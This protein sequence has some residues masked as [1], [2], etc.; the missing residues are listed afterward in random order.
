MDVVI[1]SRFNGPPA[2]ANG[3]YAAGVLAGFVAGT[4]EV[5]LLRPPPLD[6]PM[7]VIVE[8]DR[9]ALRHGDVVVAT[10]R[11]VT[12]E[13]FPVPPVSIEAARAASERGT[14][15]D[16]AAAAPFASCFTCGPDRAA[17]D[18]L[19]VFAGVVDGSPDLL[20]APWSP[21]ADVADGDGVVP[22]PV[23]WAALDC[24]GGWAA[25]LDAG[26]P[27]LLG[28]MTARIDRPVIAGE[29]HV[30]T[31]RS[32]GRNNRKLYA[33]TSIYSPDGTC[34][35]TAAATWITVDLETP[36]GARHD[37]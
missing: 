36:N 23:V 1:E 37:R 13:V 14:G 34:V 31:A 33:V 28:R 4:A 29:P 27:A 17:G 8:D 30:I 20:A 10:A 22:D 12:F 9:V 35:A 21:S 24:P 15:L 32:I 18:G 5:T 3:G 26:R 2:S 25:M 16:L 11:Q 7:T 19:G 6:T